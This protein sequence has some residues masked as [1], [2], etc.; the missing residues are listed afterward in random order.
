MNVP[1]PRRVLIATLAMTTASG[2][3]TYTR[4]LALALLR[5][6]WTPIVYTSAL[7]PQA[8]VLRNAT[9]SVVT[10]PAQLGTPPD[11]IHGHHVLETL[12]AMARFPNVPALFVCHDSLSWHSIPPRM[13]GLRAYVAVDRNCRDRMAFEHGIPAESIRVLTNPVDLER[14]RRREPLPPKPRRAL[15][16]SNL[17]MEN[18]FVAPIRAAC[19]ERGIEVDVIGLWSGRAVDHPEEVLPRYDLVFGKARCALEAAASGAAVIVCDARGMAGMLTRERV[20]ALRLLNLGA[21]TLQVPATRE[22]LLREI[23]RYDPADAA[24]VTDHIR[25]SNSSDL[26]AGQFVELY[27]ELLAE[28]VEAA[29]ANDLEAISANLVRTGQQLYSQLA[30]HN[31]RQ[32]TLLKVLNSRVLGAPLRLAWR[33]KKRLQ[34]PR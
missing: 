3:V 17:A 10:D 8:D 22:N 5:H 29:A 21:R 25:A 13:P 31:A 15:V 19:A 11:V 9:V 30:A 28:P 34:A 2:T 4:D 1:E 6:G 23:D 32:E 16:F 20:E 12:G 26:I 14:F 27:D 7:G 24:A 18:T 33:W